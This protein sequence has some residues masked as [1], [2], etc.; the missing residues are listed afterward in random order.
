MIPT[1][2]PTAWR[3]RCGELA[4][5]YVRVGVFGYLDREQNGRLPRIVN[6]AVRPFLGP[7]PSRRQPVEPAS[8][9]EYTD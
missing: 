6:E 5:H 4:I 8:N 9:I 7:L 3:L 2:F 1:R